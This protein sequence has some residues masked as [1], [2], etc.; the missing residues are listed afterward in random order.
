MKIETSV[1]SI[2]GLQQEITV[3]SHRRPRRGR[4]GHHGAQQRGADLDLHPPV[5]SVRTAA[6]RLPERTAGRQPRWARSPPPEPGGQR[7][8]LGLTRTARRARRPAGGSGLTYQ[9]VGTL[10]RTSARQPS[11]TAGP[12]TAAT[13][14]SPAKGSTTSSADPG[15]ARVRPVEIGLSGRTRAQ[16]TRSRCSTWPT[17]ATPRVDAHPEL[18][19]PLRSRCWSRLRPSR[20]MHT[21]R[22]ASLL[23][24]PSGIMSPCPWPNR[25]AIR[26]LTGSPSRST[27][28]WVAPAC[29]TPRAAS[30]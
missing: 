2:G 3:G 23:A 18:C 13:G 9:F 8:H 16:A 12:A 1:R 4:N 21:V 17:S 30:N 5:L 6:G 14:P 10:P 26:S 29:W 19:A 24:G 20:G 28:T 27:S 7:A 15:S 22:G 25:S 11:S